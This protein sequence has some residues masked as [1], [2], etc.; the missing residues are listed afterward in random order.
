MTLTQ[1]RDNGWLRPHTSSREEIGNLLSIARRDLS[2]AQSGEISDD[3]RFGIAYNP[4]S[5]NLGCD[6]LK[7]P[8]VDG[9]VEAR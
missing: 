4:L 6:I 5:A 1:W 8:T 7:F 9:G 3:W 2:D